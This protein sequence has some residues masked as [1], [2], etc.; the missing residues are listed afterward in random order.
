MGVNIPTGDLIQQQ[1]RGNWKVV[2]LIDGVTGTAGADVVSSGEDVS[3]YTYKTLEVSTD[4]DCIVY[5]Q[6]SNDNSNWYDPLKYQVGDSGT[7]GDVTEAYDCNNEKRSIEITR[8]CR[9]LRVWV[10]CTAEAV[11]TVN[12][13]AQM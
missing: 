9:Y 13:I 4:A 1:H 7:P 10:H 12:L 5:Y 11:V 2:T 6:T 8:T 3:L